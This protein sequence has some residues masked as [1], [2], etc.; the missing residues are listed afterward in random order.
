MEK[1]L[2]KGGLYG[3]VIGLLLALLFCS[4]K[5]TVRQAGNVIASRDLPMRDYILKLLR[6]AAG[7]SLG[8]AAVLWLREWIERDGAAGREPSFWA[9]Y[10]KAFFVVLAIIIVLMLLSALVSK[11]L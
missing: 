9:G 4:D 6:Y 11:W 2:V 5:E 1:K 10:F 7:C 8:T 3:F